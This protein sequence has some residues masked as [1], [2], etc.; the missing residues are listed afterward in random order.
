MRDSFGTGTEGKYSKPYQILKKN[1]NTNHW[2]GEIQ[3]TD[4]FLLQSDK[5]GTLRLMAYDLDA[6]PDHPKYHSPNRRSGQE[7]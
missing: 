7:G 5:A 2:T 3:D 4:V 6:G 1:I